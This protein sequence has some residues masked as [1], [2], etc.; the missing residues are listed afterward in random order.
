MKLKSFCT[1]K[2]TIIRT[3]QQPTERDRFLLT[4]H[5]IEVIIQNI[6][7]TKKQKTK[8]KKTR[9]QE[10]SIKNWGTELNTEF[11]KEETQMAEKHLRNFDILSLQ[12]NA[13]QTTLSFHP[14]RVSKINKTNDSSC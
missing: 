13:N 2:E 10:N 5:L 7:R 6:Y 12:R 1:A 14:I 3:K 9:Y 8:I 4:T 11:S